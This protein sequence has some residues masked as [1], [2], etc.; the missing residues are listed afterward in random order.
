MPEDRPGGM[1][2]RV[3]KAAMDLAAPGVQMTARKPQLSAQ[4]GE[5][6][7]WGARQHL[8][9]RSGAQLVNDEVADRLDD[10]EPRQGD[11]AQR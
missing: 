2:A 3:R 9:E 7:R 6:R 1:F 4:H 5:W 10:A 8:A 11:L